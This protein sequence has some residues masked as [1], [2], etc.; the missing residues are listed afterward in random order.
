MET[1]GHRFSP[2]FIEVLMSF[3]PPTTFSDGTI[4]TAANLRGNEE[5][6]KI[7]LHRGIVAGDF[8]SAKWI[9]TRHIQPP[10][11]EPFSGVQH[12][13]SG[14]QGGQWAG[15][16]EIR[17]QF[18]TKYLSGQGRQDSDAVHAFPQTSFEID[19]RRDARILYHYWWEAEVGNDSST[20]TYQVAEAERRM[21][22]IPFIAGGLDNAIGFFNSRAIDGRNSAY[23]VGVSYPIGTAE[24]YPQGGGY[25]AKQGT[26][27]LDYASVGSTQ[28]GL[29]IH[30][31]VDRCGLVNWGC[32]IE[33]Y[34][35]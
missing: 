24:T 13:V 22:I 12:G 4:L 32:I 9:D 20:A 28:A 1:R 26:I 7:Y 14:H 34:Y 6:L 3:A 11:K 21:T 33:A 16:A 2:V 8:E 30:S 35:L 17:L 15:G 5:A 27:A 23:G 25:H 18:A 29:A 10:Y 31:T 19:I